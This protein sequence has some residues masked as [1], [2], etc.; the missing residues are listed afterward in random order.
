[1][2][3]KFPRTQFTEQEILN[4]G[5]DESNIAPTS[6]RGSLTWA[7]GLGWL[8]NPVNGVFPYEQF[9]YTSGNIDYKGINTDIAAADTDPDWIIFKYT[10]TGDNCTKIQ[11]RITSWTLRASGW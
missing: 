9:D 4:M 6:L 7:K 3:D 2:A 1:M 5:L 10:W 11:M 8:R